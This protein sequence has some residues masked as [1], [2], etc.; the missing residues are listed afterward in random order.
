[1]VVRCAG[2]RREVAYGSRLQATTRVEPS[3]TTVRTLFEAAREA[4]EG[5]ALIAEVDFTDSSGDAAAI[6]E[7]SR[8]TEGTRILAPFERPGSTPN[9][10]WN[11]YNFELHPNWREQL[12]GWTRSRLAV[13]DRVNVDAILNWLDEVDPATKVFS[14][15]GDLI[16][17]LA[18][19]HRAGIPERSAGLTGLASEW[20]S[21]VFGRESQA[22][23]RRFGRD[24][25]E[26]I[27]AERVRRLEL[28]LEPLSISRLADLLPENLLSHSPLTSAKRGKEGNGGTDSASSNARDAVQSLADK[29]VFVLPSM[30]G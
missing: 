10:G 5:I 21:Q 12:V 23:L 28:V 20:L 22:W 8:R 6:T 25:V 19:I 9:D 16:A 3:A 11:T 1:M 30:A 15:P 27:A 17:I 26:H 18:R 4:R 7:L 13:P 29:G 24:A 2:R 14:T